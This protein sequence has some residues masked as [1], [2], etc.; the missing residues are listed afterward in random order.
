MG[1]Q[2]GCQA[3]Q[4]EAVSRLISLALRSGV[5]PQSVIEQLKGNRCPQVAWENGGTTLSCADAI[6]KAIERHIIG[7]AAAHGSAGGDVA[8]LLGLCPQCPECSGTM[9]VSGGCIVCRSCGF[10]KCP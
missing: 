10:S 5:A 1:K 2:G 4:A 8:E 9:E 3:S 7:E 6:S